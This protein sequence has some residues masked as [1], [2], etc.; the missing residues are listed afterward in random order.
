MQPILIIDGNN[1]TLRAMHGCPALY[2]QKGTPTGCLMTSVRTLCKVAREV[3]PKRVVWTWDGGHSAYRKKIFPAYKQRKEL[4]KLREEL[5]EGSPSFHEEWKTQVALLE[6]YLPLLGVGQI[7]IPGCEADDVIYSLKNIFTGQGVSV[8][9]ATSDAD[10]NQLLDENFFVYNLAREELCGPDQVRMKYGISPQQWI[11]FRAMT[12]DPSDN[13]D[14]IPGVG[15]KRA[16]EILDQYGSLPKFL[17]EYYTGAISSPKKFHKAVAE[18]TEIL[19][20]NC[21]LMDLA[22]FNFEAEFSNGDVHAR[23]W[24]ALSIE[25]DLKAF[26][27]V[28]MDHQLATLTQESAMWKALYDA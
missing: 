17:D 22:W 2:D 12:G 19:I 3:K 16:A 27:N 8:V 9:L 11:E 25:P 20:R 6:R 4:P 24:E 28:C 21:K 14:G 10:F 15:E 13:I 26:W 23:L 5:E 1:L 7:R 18:N